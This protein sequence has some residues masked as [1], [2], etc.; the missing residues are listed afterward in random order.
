MMNVVILQGRLTDKPFVKKTQ[1]GKS[2]CSF[3]IACDRDFDRDTAD[4]ID[5]VAWNH[6]AEFISNYFDRGN[7]IL[8]Q[9]RLQKRTYTNKEGSKVTREETIVESVW[10]GEPSYRVKSDPG[11]EYGDYDELADDSDLPF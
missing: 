7:M 10:F 2:V 9:G 8:V 4:F 5:C 3:T 6:N 11:Q 1:S